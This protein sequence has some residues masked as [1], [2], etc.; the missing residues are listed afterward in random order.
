MRLE[1][2]PG[3]GL[4]HSIR[5]SKKSTGLWAV[6]E[7]KRVFFLGRLRESRTKMACNLRSDLGH[8]GGAL[9][10]GLIYGIA[11]MLCL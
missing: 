1:T 4:S 2:L 8:V 10:A 11:L 9:R 6:P 3:H 5:L 7:Q